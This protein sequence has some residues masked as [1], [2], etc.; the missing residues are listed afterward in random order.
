MSAAASC[1][2]N[3]LLYMNWYHVLLYLKHQYLCQD[4]C[5]IVDYSIVWLCES[6]HGRQDGINILDN[7]HFESTQGKLFDVGGMGCMCILNK[8][9][10]RDS[11][12]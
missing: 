8:L 9:K 7:I 10:C 11:V 2:S 3:I 6:T 5:V 4:S 12:C 1:T